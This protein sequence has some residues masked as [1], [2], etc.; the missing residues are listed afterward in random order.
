M[1]LP[2]GTLVWADLEPV[3]GH[4]QGGKRPVLVV[5]RDRFNEKS[6]TVIAFAVTTARPPVG[7]PFA[8]EVPAG[9]LPKPSWVKLSQVRTLSAQRLGAPIGVVAPDLVRKCLE[10][11]LEHCQR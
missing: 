3:R 6:G 1:T 11:L 7:Y 2:R 10:G 9:L 8:L 4:E 5:S